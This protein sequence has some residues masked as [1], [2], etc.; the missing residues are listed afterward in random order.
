MADAVAFDPTQALNGLQGLLGQIGP[1]QADIAAANKARLMDIAAGLLGAR[2]GFEFSALGQGLEKGQ[3]DYANMLKTL[4]AIRATNLQ[5]LLPLA[6]MN[7][8]MQM[9]NNFTGALNAAQQPT[10]VPGPDATFQSGPRTAADA[11]TGNAPPPVNLPTQQQV[12]A[13][14]VDPSLRQRLA[15]A[16]LGLSMFGVNAT[17]ALQFMFPQPVRVNQGGGVYDPAHG[18]FNVIPKAPEGAQP[19]QGP[20]GQWHI[21]VVPGA[22]GAEGAVSGTRAGASAVGAAMGKLPHP[23]V[24]NQTGRD[25]LPSG[26]LYSQLYPR[27][28]PFGIGMGAN[29]A[30]AATAAAVAPGAANAAAAPAPQGAAPQGPTAAPSPGATTELSPEQEETFKNAAEFEKA[31]HVAADAA[32]TQ[33]GRLNEMRQLLTYF[34]PSPWLPLEA[35]AGGY[36]QAIP[37]IGNRLASAFVPNAATALP[38]IQAF[39]KNTIQ[40]A[41][42]QSRVLGSREAAQIVQMLRDA[43]PNIGMVPGAPQTVMAFM[44]GMNRYVL[45]TEQNMMKW[46]QANGTVNGFKEAWHASHP[47]TSYLPPLSALQNIAQGKPP[48]IDLTSGAPSGDAPDAAPQGTASTPMPAFTLTDKGRANPTLQALLKRETPNAQQLQILRLNGLVQ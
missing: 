2:R 27:G 30:P 45:D 25:F 15:Q 47:M 20:D 22:L 32:S 24:D 46:K 39:T 33:E 7:M 42:D 17:P 36:L 38:A 29:V 1:S 14:S 13:G 4:P 34:K 19:V 12:P 16:N 35:K 28:D 23:L 8:R 9:L 6:Q 26:A 41:A 43:N 11:F 48:G 40:F 10:T 3:A 31:A 18:T 5:S 44:S 37:G 21:E